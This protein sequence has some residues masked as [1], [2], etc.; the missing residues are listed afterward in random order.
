MTRAFVCG[1]AGRALGPEERAFIRDARPWGLILFKRN[2]V[3]REQLRALIQSFRDCRRARRRARADRSGRRAGAA[4]GAAA[5]AGLSRRRPLRAGG[6]TGARRLARGAAHRPRSAAKSGSPSI[7]RRCSTSPTAAMHAAIGARAFSSAPERVAALGRAVCDGLI[8]GGVLPVVKHMP[9]HGRASADSHLELPVVAASRAELAAR[10]FAPFAALRDA[11]MAMSAHVVYGA[12]DPE[13]PATTSP[14]VVKEIMRGAIG[15]DGLILSDDLSMKALSGPF[16]ARARAAFAAGLDIALHCNGDLGEARA[17]AEATPGTRGRFASSRRR[18]PGAHRR[19]AA[20]VR[21]RGGARRTRGDD[22]GGRGGLRRFQAR[23]GGSGRVFVLSS[24]AGVERNDRDP[25]TRGDPGCR[26]RRLQPARRRGRGSHA[27]AAAGAAQ[28]SDRSDDRR[29]HGRVV[30]RTGDGALVEFRSV[31]DAVRCAIEVQ[32]AMVER[33]AGVPRRSSHRVSH[34][35]SSRR[36]RRGERR[37]SDG[38]RRQYRRAV[39]RD[40]HARRDLPVRGCLSAGEGA[41]RSGGQRSRRRPA[42]EHR[43]ADAGLF[44]AGRP[45]ARPARRRP[46]PLRRKPRRASR[47]PTSRRSPCCRFRT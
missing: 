21:R 15:F 25:E 35:H 43:R 14:I 7:A 36:R 27:G 1:C 10:D 17:V 40:R 32:N 3:D 44:A 34:R 12:I 9:G 39:G 47:Y 4:H 22:G 46:R 29:A 42:Q 18:R 2:V 45:P 16:A 6:R 37:R 24:L 41:A 19:R 23:S 26:R 30:K 11:P 13:S 28:R 5:L 31:V 38:R 8:A 33:N 20:A